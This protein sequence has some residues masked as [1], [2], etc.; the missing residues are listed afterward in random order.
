MKVKFIKTWLFLLALMVTISLHAGV[1]VN[2]LNQ[3]TQDYFGPI[4]D[5]SNTNDFLIGQ[6]FTLPASATPYR[7]DQITLLLTATGGG[8]NITVSIWQVGSDNNPTNE[9]A[10]VASRFVA[11]AGSVDFVSTTNMTLS[12]GIYYVVAAPTTP[13]DSG[14]VS[15]AYAINTNWSGSGVLGGFADTRAGAWVNVSITNLPQQLSV[16]AT[17]RSAKIGARQQGSA[18]ILSWPS[19]LQGYVAESTTNLSSPAWQP[20]TNAPTPVAGNSTITNRGSEPARFFRLRQSLV[21]DNLEQPVSDWAGPIGTDANNNDFLIGQEFT[22]PDGNYALNKVT[23]LL[24]PVNGSGTVTVSIWH[25][26]L[27]NNPTNEI[28]VVSSQL[29]SQAGNVDFVPSAP[30]TLSQG[31]Y[32]VVAAPATSADN[33]RVGWDW[34]FSTTWTGFGALGRFADTSPGVWENFPMGFGPYQMSIQTTSV[35]P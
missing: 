10:T 20:I 12:P 32:Y 1:I 11:N 3:P 18:T 17:R 21:A 25:A 30:I 6:E 2:N 19:A 8:A 35:A 31:T 29:V 15:W 4:G 33:A 13:A 28:A 22:L 5:D 9:I 16:Q 27:D 7:L 23:L 26:G 14:F 24:D 34:T